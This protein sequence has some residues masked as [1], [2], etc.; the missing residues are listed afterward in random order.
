MVSNKVRRNIWL[1]LSFL[2]AGCVI[3]RGIRVASGELEWWNLV[4]VIVILALCIKFYLCYRKQVKRG[5]LYGKVN[6]IR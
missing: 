6:P 2:S 4:S 1:V 5:N 3:D